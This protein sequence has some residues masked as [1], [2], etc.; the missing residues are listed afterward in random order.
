[1]D[2][3]APPGKPASVTTRP[4]ADI[5]N[6]DGCWREKTREKL[7]RTFAVELTCART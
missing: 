5:E 4:T 3:V 7:T 6:L 2:L 1:M